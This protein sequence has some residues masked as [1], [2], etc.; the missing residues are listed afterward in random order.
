MVIVEANKANISSS[1]KYFL[2]KKITTNEKINREYHC[3][4][5]KFSMNWKKPNKNGL[6]AG[7]AI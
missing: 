3:F 5:P 1:L 2:L 4:T 7:Y 6:P